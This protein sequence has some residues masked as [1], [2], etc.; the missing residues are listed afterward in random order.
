MDRICDICRAHA[1][2]DEQEIEHTPNCPHNPNRPA[3]PSDDR[4][5][6]F[7]LAR[8]DK[9]SKPRE[10]RPEDA[11]DLARAWIEESGL[12]APDHIIVFIGRTNGDNSSGTKY[13]QTGSFSPHAQVGLVYEGLDMIRESGK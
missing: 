10:H 1:V 5:V 7:A 3:Q 8:A 12:E 4:V 9:G 2:G 6:S 13:F 11:L